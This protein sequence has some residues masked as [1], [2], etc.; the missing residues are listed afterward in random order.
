MTRPPLRDFGF[1]LIELAMVLFIVSLLIGGLLMPLA[2]QTEIRGRQETDRALANIR[3][4]LIGYAVVNGRLPCPAP[5][6]LA[7]GATG[8]GLEATT[9]AAGTT[10]TT[11]PCGCT[12]ATSGI[13]S[14]GGTA[15]DDTTPGGVRG[16]L[17]W[18]TLGLSEADAWGNRYNYRVTTRFARLASGQT[19]F[20]ACTPATNP[21]A[22]AVALCSAGDM[23][24]KT[25]VAG[26]DIA[27]AVPV[28]VVS[29]GKNTLGAY[30]QS[31]TQ[32]TGVVAGS[33]EEENANGDAN[34]VSST[35]IDDQLVWLP[36]S[37]LMG[38]MLSAGRLP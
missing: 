21:T 4:A 14:A 5:A 18:A 35:N 24:I 17:P 19:A 30:M 12:A 13:A 9:A 22:A 7:T 37:I 1:T 26:T 10:T 15:C 27:T 36:T 25:T 20:G 23:S 16:V 8:A 34:F 28:I 33:D 11:G 38:R 6:T 3:E 29:H 2:A 31:G 32:I